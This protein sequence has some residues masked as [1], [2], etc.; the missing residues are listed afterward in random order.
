MCGLSGI[1]VT[2]P[3][4]LPIEVMKII[5]SLLMEENDDRGGHSWGAW[6]TNTPPIR[7]LGKYFTN[8]TPLHEHLVDFRYADEGLTYLFGHT[9]F[10]THG[11]RTVENAHPFEEGNLVLA[12]NG[13]VTVD[14][15]TDQDHAVDSGRIAQAIVEHGYTAGMERV[16]GMCALL[17]TVGGHPYIYR[18]EQ[19]LNCAIFDWGTVISSTLYD[20]EAVVK[21]RLGL[22]PNEIGPVPEDMFCQ[23][24]FGRVALSAPAKQRKAYTPSADNTT[25]WWE[26]KDGDDRFTTFPYERGS[27]STIGFGG[28]RN[29]SGKSD[30]PGTTVPPVSQTPAPKS[31]RKVT[32]RRRNKVTRAQ[33]LGPV[34][35]SC[36]QAG[37]PKM[38]NGDVVDTCEYCGYATP[39]DD[40]Y[41][42]LV[43]W[44]G[45]YPLMMCLDCIMDEIATNCS[46][47]VLGPYNTSL[48]DLGFEEFDDR[49]K[50]NET[51]E[52]VIDAE[53]V[54][55]DV[56]DLR[57][58]DN[59][60]VLTEVQQLELD[61]YV[62]GGN[63]TAL[64]DV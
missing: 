30:L 55:Q 19:V 63:I 53:I 59:P 32:R 49:K 7:A 60:D 61:E 44:G 57:P 15:Y 23:P 36:G 16:S 42:C 8:P 64:H 33:T 48:T 34:P 5:F 2:K 27:R 40:L 18:H 41:L 31:Q 11:E 38:N 4:Q 22:V 10:G 17:L 62:R 13:V 1:V 9:R 29:F 58:I 43:E 26:E 46:M 50:D 24:G 3:D 21:K 47:N 28:G 45:A 52:G 20:L 35:I 56:P 51:D 12:H 37:G 14:G 39:I 25:R 54:N 6:G